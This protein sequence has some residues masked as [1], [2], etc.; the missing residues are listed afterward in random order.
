MKQLNVPSRLCVSIAFF[1]IPLTLLLYVYT[2]EITKQIDFASQEKRGNAY[3]RPLVG[4][5]SDVNL[6]QVGAWKLH[7]GDATATDAMKDATNRIA[8]H[9][10]ALEAAQQQYG[11]VLQFTPEGLKS[12]KRES[13]T[14][15]NLKAQW[16]AVEAVAMDPAKTA[17]L[18]P[19]YQTV[20]DTL[21]GMIAHAGDM[22][23]LIL[24]PDLDSYYTMDATLLALP[25]AMG[26]F[27]QMTG[28]I[29]PM[30]AQPDLSA[31]Q[32]VQLANFAAMMNEA[33]VVRTTGDM[34]TAFNEDANF[35]G[36][37]P[38]LKTNVTP[39]I[40]DFSQMTTG[41]R[42]SLETMSENP[43]A[44]PSRTLLDQLAA[45]QTTSLA[46][47]ESATDELD[48]LLDKRIA[49]FT[50]DRLK[51]LIAACGAIVLA[52]VAFW[53]VVR[54]IT[55]PLKQLRESMVKIS[56]GQLETDVPCLTLRDEIGS[57]A[58]TVEIFKENSIEARTLEVEKRKEQEIKLE[59]QKNVDGMIEKFRGTVGALID[60][61]ERSSNAMQ[62]MGQQVLDA[63]GET[64]NLTMSV[65]SSTNEVS[66]NVSMVAS[67]AEELT[68]AIN[69]ISSQISRSTSATSEAVAQTSSAD[70]TVQLLAN[71]AAKIGEV[72]D[73]IGAIAE[74]INLLALNATIESARAG[75]AGKG[76]AVVAGE[77]KNLAGQTSKATENITTQITEVQGS[78]R[79]VVEAL[80]QIQG[81][82]EGINH[83]ASTI[84]AAVEEQGAATRD[85]ARNI[86]ITSDRVSEVSGN[87][88]QVNSVAV[89]TN[90]NA[91]S[92]LHN[93]ESFT[94]QTRKLQSEVRNFL[95]GI[96]AA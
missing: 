38:T 75:E 77:V 35:Y 62:T 45:A 23:N 17:E 10:K 7:T 90:D 67:A 25:Q 53:Y 87:V 20:S 9:M 6:H 71:S 93:L 86:Q 68:A 56:D 40:A 61:V 18:P 24:D 80:K 22:S 1:V 76:F 70:T 73:M 8:T 51:T 72:S 41:L 52:F 30:L 85:I 34:D 26:R 2:G 14:I 74:Q 28:T 33:D 16:S 15:A 79:H 59:R 47:W 95:Q 65:A 32:K 39:K 92:M 21:R 49:S 69:E 64:K 36:V 78:T 27:G 5:L 60:E 63:A 11:D 46:L 13:M 29:M 31:K 66:N 57:M 19:L 94:S 91:Q 42:T 12:R 48:V 96:A 58:K 54:T 4:L 82:I 89:T 44:V 83:I 3:L 50:A 37:S 84:A 55:R 88:Q 43:S 81:T